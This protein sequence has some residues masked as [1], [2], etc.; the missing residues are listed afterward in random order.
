M[1]MIKTTYQ[2]IFDFEDALAEHTGAPYAIV[3][4]GCTHGLELCLRYYGIKKFEQTAFTYLS[5]IQMYRQLGIDY[6][7]T[8]EKWSGEYKLHGTNIWDSA[9]K[10]AKGMYRKGDIQ[11]LSFGI[12]KPLTVGR[13]GALKAGAILLDDATAYKDISRMRADGRDLKEFPHT[14]ATEWAEQGVFKQAYHYMPTLEDCKTGL[15]LLST[16]EGDID[17][18][19]DYPDLRTITF[20]E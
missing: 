8:D 5:V 12:N 11:S 6:T 9:R 13:H 16:M 7:L 19:V 3:T 20:E 10:L 14:G 18:G 2:A 17:Q 15:R 4:T 1:K